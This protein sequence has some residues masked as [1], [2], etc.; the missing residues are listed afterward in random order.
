MVCLGEGGGWREYKSG[1]GDLIDP[2]GRRSP[3][4]G[5]NGGGGSPAP[6]GAGR[7]GMSHYRAAGCSPAGHSTLYT[8]LCT[9]WVDQR[10]FIC[11]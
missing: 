11:R 3:L 5:T 10:G 7:R 2:V 8:L 4:P 9:S 1:L 6:S